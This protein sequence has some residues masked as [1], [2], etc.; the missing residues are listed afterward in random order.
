MIRNITLPQIYVLTA[1]VEKDRY[2]LEIINAVK[3]QSNYK[4]IVGSLYNV[5]AKLER[6]GLVES[7][8]KDEKT[9]ERR[10]NR[11]RYYKITGT[12]IEAIRGVQYG[13]SSMWNRISFS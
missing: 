3:E 12:G 9:N 7:Y 13:L 5:L 11:R 1:L 4:I 10:G 8:W 6:E 2:G